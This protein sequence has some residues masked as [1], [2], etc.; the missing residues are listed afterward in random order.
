MKR[1]T[2]VGSLN[3]DLVVRAPRAPEAGE[4]VAGESL[5]RYPG[6][7]GGNQAAAAARLCRREDA[8]P[9]LASAAASD[10][11][12]VSLIGRVGNDGEGEFLLGRLAGAG[13]DTSGVGRDDDHG[14]G[15][16][17]I[18]VAA[19]TGENRIVLIAGANEALTPGVLG[20]HHDVLTAADVLLL[21]LEIPLPTVQTA[22]RMGREKR[23]IVI[24][25]PAPA[26]PLP[27]ALLRLCDFVTPNRGEL[28]LLVRAAAPSR[29][30]LSEDD[31][32]DLA[33]V[34]TQAHALAALGARH[35]VVKLGRH[36]VLICTP[37][38]DHHVPGFAVTAVDTTAAGD[39]WNGAFAV[40]LCEGRPLREAAR[41]ANAAAAL[42]VTRKGAQ[43][44]I[45]TRAEVDALLASQGG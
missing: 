34:A 9:D 42:S 29:A 14:T 16:A 2:A 5:T 25:D 38:G 6:G 40:A 28:A 15:I 39:T 19:T 37:Q 45:P 3:V 33:A 4:T 26:R 44:S 11:I 24:L 7:K 27:A 43:A 20:Q 35:V 32:P 12:A 30:D 36:G 21:Q 31:A 22:A 13:V 23:A 10:P 8:A 41:F 1:I 18:T 17:A